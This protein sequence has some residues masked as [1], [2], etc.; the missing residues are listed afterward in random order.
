MLMGDLIM[1]SNR[2]LVAE[3][4]DAV[5]RNIHLY[6]AER[7]F[8][9]CGEAVDGEDA[10]EKAKELKPDLILLDLAMPR[11]N[12]IEAASVLKDIMPNVPIVLFTM[13]TEAIGKAFGSLS[14]VDAMVAKAEGMGKLVDC[15]Q[16][17]LGPGAPK[18]E[19]TQLA[20]ATAEDPDKVRGEVFRRLF[21]GHLR[22]PC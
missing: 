13:Y 18:T 17:L 16:N 21:P 9:V 6:L 22:K 14:H 8:E 1:A 2:I 5:R 12:G 20:N 7:D 10:I 3:D 4:S 19:R 15:V 11:T